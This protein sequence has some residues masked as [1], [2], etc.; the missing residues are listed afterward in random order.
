MLTYDV[1][2]LFRDRTQPGHDSGGDKPANETVRRLA[3]RGPLDNAAGQD[4][5]EVQ[6]VLCGH[7]QRLAA[8]AVPWLASTERS[9]GRQPRHGAAPCATS[10]NA[11]Q[12]L[13]RRGTCG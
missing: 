8:A 1:L 6:L 13:M 7:M 9:A 3:A 5:G 11:W 4:P 10:I 2:P 12:G